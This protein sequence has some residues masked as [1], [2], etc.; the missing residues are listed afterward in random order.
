MR[1]AFSY[2]RFSSERQANGDSLRRQLALTQAYCDRQG[3]QLD[4]S[5]S[6]LDRAVSAH[7]GENAEA[8]ALARF[9]EA[10]RMGTVP[11]GAVLIVESLDRLSRSEIFKALDLFKGLLDAGIDI[12][13]LQPEREYTRANVSALFGLFEPLLILSRAHEESATKSARVKA[14]WQRKREQLSE[15]PA[16]SRC[17]A[18]LRLKEDRTGFEPIPDAVA[19]VLRVHAL[20]RD[21]HGV[22]QITRQLREEGIAPIA[23]K[24]DGWRGSYV[25]KLLRTRAVLGEYQPYVVQD[26]KLVPHGQPVP[27]YFPA[28]M[29]E[30]EWLATRRAVELRLNQRGPRG[31]GVRN[32]FTGIL[33]DARDGCSMVIK[34]RGH[35]S[36]TTYLISS[37]AWKR[38]N[39]SPGFTF[40]Y[41]LIE[42]WT[43][44]FLSRDLVDALVQEGRRGKASQIAALTGKLTDLDARIRAG[45]KVADTA[46]DAESVLE[47][48]AQWD[49]V[50]K[51]TSEAL[52]QLQQEQTCNHAQ[53]LGEARTLRQHMAEATREELPDL[54]TRLKA[55][56]RSLI[57]EIW[58]LAEGERGDRRATV[59]LFFMSGRCLRFTIQ[60]DDR[61]GPGYA[62]GAQYAVGGQAD[63]L[64]PEE[65]LR[66]WRHLSTPPTFRPAAMKLLLTQAGI[67]EVA[68]RLEAV[69]RQ[70]LADKVNAEAAQAAEGFAAGVQ[71]AEGLDGLQA[72]LRGRLEQLLAAEDRTAGVQAA[73]DA[74]RLAGRVAQACMS[75]VLLGAG[76][77]R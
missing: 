46:R 76:P 63:K 74:A 10:V 45:K 66:Q 24:A 77:A 23:G 29:S 37:G 19:A 54:R 18:W 70:Q 59:Q 2:V 60:R 15:K 47:K 38:E 39:D 17:P 28:I 8:G 7:R 4:D 33:F 44:E 14:A 57:H 6:F 55:R 65:D 64:R 1:R 61:S 5:R 73:E 72:R 53:T 20:A 41:G 56:I 26:G 42:E 21:G 9:L 52:Q 40:P 48:L 62:L 71:A 75:A 30:A 22:Q 35:Q 51:A 16:T 31:K 69:V 43:L 50:K 58:V 12:V 3:L 68:R 25:G 67:E 36:P 34:W 11:R 13:T 49:E 32:L 27:N